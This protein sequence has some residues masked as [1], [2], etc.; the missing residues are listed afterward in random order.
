MLF[1]SIKLI[2]IVHAIFY[3]NLFF[4]YNFRN[5]NELKRRKKMNGKIMCVYSNRKAIKRNVNIITIDNWIQ[6]LKKTKLFYMYIVFTI[7]LIYKLSII[8]LNLI[9]MIILLIFPIFLV[10]KI[11]K[12]ALPPGVSQKDADLYKEIREKAANSVT[13][14]KNNTTV[15][16]TQ[17]LSPMS[18][19]MAEQERCP[20]AIEFGKFEIETWYSSPFPQEYAR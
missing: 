17:V 15:Q 11:E 20:A 2:N 8:E 3:Y 12:P 1:V 7:F 19:A 9:L 5:S 16:T 13:E 18:S 14:T 10:D 6:I 4:F